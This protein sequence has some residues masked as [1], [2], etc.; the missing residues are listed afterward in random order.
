MEKNQTPLEKLAAFCDTCWDFEAD[1]QQEKYDDLC[2]AFSQLSAKEKRDAIP[3]LVD[4]SKIYPQLVFLAKKLFDTLD[5]VEKSCLTVRLVSPTDMN[6]RRI[7]SEEYFWRIKH[8]FSCW[9]DYGCYWRPVSALDIMT[10][11]DEMEMIVAS[12]SPVII[13]CG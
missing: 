5:L 6:G 1:V 3:L 11:Q 10:F 12:N 7:C 13:L 9:Q 8:H 2:E 4:K